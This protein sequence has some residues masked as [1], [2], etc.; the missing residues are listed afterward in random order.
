MLLNRHRRNVA[1]ERQRAVPA[2]R[3]RVDGTSDALD[4]VWLHLRTTL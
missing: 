2:D 4:R 1:A 3:R